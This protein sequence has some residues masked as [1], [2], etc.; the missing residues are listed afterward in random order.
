MRISFCIRERG[1]ST[2][3]APND[4]A[5]ASNPTTSGDASCSSSFSIGDSL[6][7]IYCIV[8]HEQS[9]FAPL[10]NT[11]MS[12]RSHCARPC[13][14]AHLSVACCVVPAQ[15]PASSVVVVI[16]HSLASSVRIQSHS[17]LYSVAAALSHDV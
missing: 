16:S 8:L 11:H 5:S 10:T 17:S 12:M 9:A 3:A 7:V 1:D 2:S 15:Q 13:L 14:A 6:L 4:S